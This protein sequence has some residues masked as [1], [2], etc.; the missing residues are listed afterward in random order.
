LLNISHLQRDYLSKYVYRNAISEK[1]REKER[2]RERKWSLF[3]K[4]IKRSTLQIAW[5]V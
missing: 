1:E 4:R 3:T 5:G 2:K